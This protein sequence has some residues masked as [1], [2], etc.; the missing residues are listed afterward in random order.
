MEAQLFLA[1]LKR[2]FPRI[3]AGAPTEA[4]IRE[5]AAFPRDGTILSPLRQPVEAQRCVTLIQSPIAHQ[6]TEAL[7][8]IE[9]LFMLSDDQARGL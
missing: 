7:T 9:L 3:N 4:T 5:G 8:R 2:C 1:T 6:R